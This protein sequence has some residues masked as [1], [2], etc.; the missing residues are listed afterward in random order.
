VQRRQDFLRDYQND[1]LA[2]RYRAMVEQ[3]RQ[4]E[5][6]IGGSGAFADAVAR[7]YFKLLSYKDEY[8]VARLHTRKEFVKSIRDQ[9]GAK[10]KLRF[11]LAPPLLNSKLD[12]RGRPLKKQFG[13]W[14]LPVFSILASMRGLRGSALDIFGWTAERRME[15]A[16][17]V[18]FETLLGTLLPALTQERL[19][20]AT[21]LVELFMSI[22]GYG[23][24][25]EE[26]VRLVRQQLQARQF[27]LPH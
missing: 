8:E 22:R 14:L 11:H 18:E 7:S 12:A 19:Q 3:A 24:V 13:A 4:R 20:E 26:S 21:E 1:A 9:F 25:K 5:A 2:S 10:A 23:P 27:S 16:L 15:R 17:I 6:E